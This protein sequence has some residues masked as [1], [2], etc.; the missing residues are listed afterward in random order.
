VKRAAG[1]AFAVVWLWGLG[2]YP[3]LESTEGRYASIASAM[4]RTGDF[5]EPRYDGLLHFDKPPLAYWAGAAALRVLPHTEWSVRL[6]ATLAW[7]ASLALVAL[8][9]RN[10]G[11]DRRRALWAAALAGLAPLAVAQGRLLSSD[12]FLWVGILLF[13]LGWARGGRWVLC[14]LGLGLG[15]LAKGPIVL[16]WTLLPAL[17]AALAL[18]SRRALAGFLDLR[19][20]GLFVLVGLPWYLIEAARHP[21]LVGFW[22]GRETAGRYL[23]TVHGRAEPWWYFPA[24]LPAL[25]LPWLPEAV[26]GLW[27]SLRR[28]DASEAGPPAPSIRHLL[29]LIAFIPF[30]FLCFSSS[31]RPN[32]LLPMLGPLAILAASV[33]PSRRSRLARGWITAWTLLV[34]VS[35]FLLEGIPG[36]VPP[37]RPL[38]RAARDENRPLATFRTL[39]SSLPFYLDADVPTIDLPRGTSL[40]PPSVR[41]RWA[42]TGE[43]ALE[44]ALPEGGLVFTRARDLGAMEGTAGIVVEELA[45]RGKLRLLQVGWGAN[46]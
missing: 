19:T 33:L 15:F 44:T 37:T 5:L 39:P 36:A 41:A 26:R 12:I 13:Q 35:P 28:N 38:A 18:R 30:V 40:D 8:V 3:L 22:L 11:L 10:L 14:G 24:L 34:L 4:A 27:R 1:V 29:L 42:P 45:T 20:W 23:S 17:V 46:D 6:P 2:A 21:D 43:E 9:A 25:V 32:Y 31:K 7:L 16:M